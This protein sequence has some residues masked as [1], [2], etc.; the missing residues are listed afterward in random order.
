MLL[1]SRAAEIA[2]LKEKVAA[3]KAKKASLI[4][5]EKAND[6]HGEAGVIHI[7]LSVVI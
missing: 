6:T 2:I 3:L 5:Q 7:G 1:Q 4:V